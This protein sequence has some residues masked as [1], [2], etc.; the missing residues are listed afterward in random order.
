M[1][2]RGDVRGAAGS[3][4]GREPAPVGV[5]PLFFLGPDSDTGLVS[6]LGTVEPAAHASFCARVAWSLAR[7]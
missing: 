2:E 4:R 6:E 5:P 7:L 3:L 1:P